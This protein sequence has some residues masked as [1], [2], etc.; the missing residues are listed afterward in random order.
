MTTEAGKAFEIAK[1]A[2]E[3]L[4]VEPTMFRGF[5]LVDLRI[6]YQA[7]DD[8]TK[9]VYKPTRKGVTFKRDLIPEVVD[10]LQK[11]AALEGKQDS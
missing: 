7:S 4:R 8:P 11:I 5:R 10:A 2:T 6:W 3:R 1:N 9:P